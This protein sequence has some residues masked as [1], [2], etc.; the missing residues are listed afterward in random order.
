MCRYAAHACDEPAGLSS[1]AAGIHAIRSSLSAS[2]GF[3][4]ALYGTSPFRQWHV[5]PSSACCSSLSRAAYLH[6]YSGKIH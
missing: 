6:A 1:R 2:A 5:R 3:C 4:G